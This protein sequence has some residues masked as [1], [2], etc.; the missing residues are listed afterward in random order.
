MKGNTIFSILQ[1]AIAIWGIVIVTSGKYLHCSDNGMQWIY[2]SNMGNFFST[3]HVIVIIAQCYLSVKIFYYVPKKH[4]LLVV[5][6]SDSY[7]KLSD[8]I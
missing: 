3:S 8:D 5:D 7:K 6:D 4:G 1:F 2:T